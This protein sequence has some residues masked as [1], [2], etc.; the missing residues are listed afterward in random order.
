MSSVQGVSLWQQDQNYWSQSQAQSSASSA[1]S[2]LIGVISTAM[3]DQAKGLASIANGTA[4]KRVNSALSA[5]VQNAL[6]V[7]DGDAPTS[8]SST[9]SSSS[10]SSSSTASTPAT[11]TPAQAVG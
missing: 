1:Q 3:V 4:L 10:S 5:A 6:Q 11:P 8:S 9:S 7:V 2:A